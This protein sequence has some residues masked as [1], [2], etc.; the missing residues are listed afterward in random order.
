VVIRE[1]SRGQGIKDSSEIPKNYKPYGSVCKPGLQ[2][3][4]A[5]DLDLTERAYWVDKKG[6]VEI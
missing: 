5:G 1:D 4:L 3:L 6:I 2:I